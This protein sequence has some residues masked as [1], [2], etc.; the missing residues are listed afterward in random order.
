MRQT[1][2]ARHP[3]TASVRWRDE[4]SCL[5]ETSRLGPGYRRA[6]AL[7]RDRPWGCPGEG[8]RPQLSSRVNRKRG[9]ACVAAA[10]PV[11][12]G[13]RLVLGFAAVQTGYIGNTSNR[14]H[15]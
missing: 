3:L 9:Y 14:E 2:Q 1:A 15:G 4:P 6:Y 11:A 13:L 8:P 7:H 5:A 12:P 10:T